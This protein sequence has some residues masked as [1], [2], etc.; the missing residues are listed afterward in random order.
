[1]FTNQKEMTLCFRGS[2]LLCCELVVL[3]S[4][5]AYALLMCLCAAG[6]H[7]HTRYPTATCGM[8]L[9]E[10]LVCSSTLLNELIFH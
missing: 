6:R 5:S 4:V 1:M 9:R 8:P 3:T 2:S 10:M 7:M